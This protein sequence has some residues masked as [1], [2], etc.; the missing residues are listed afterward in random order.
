M[1]RKAWLLTGGIVMLGAIG[2][3]ALSL[4]SGKPAQ[5]EPVTT[6]SPSPTVTDPGDIDIPKDATA[7]SPETQA[8]SSSPVVSDVK[9]DQEPTIKEQPVLQPDKG[10]QHVEAP[11]TEPEATPKPTESPKPEPKETNKPQSTTSPPKNEKKETKPSEPKEEPKAGEQG[12]SGKVY[13]PGFGW[14]EDS[15]DNKG[16]QSS[17]DGDWDKQVGTMD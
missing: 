14:V 5:T 11:I 1:K 12:N 7:N 9:P 16:E 17:S 2:I 15:G 10:P 8:P 3:W 4:S 13:V 6:V